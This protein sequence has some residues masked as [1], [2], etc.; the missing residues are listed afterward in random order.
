MFAPAVAGIACRASALAADAVTNA[1]ANPASPLR[2]LS[3][4]PF[5]S[6]WSSLFR[7]L[8]ALAIVLAVF[9]GGVW[10][11]RNWQ[12]VVQRRGAAPRLNIVESRSLGGRHALYVVAFEQERFLISSSPTG[13]NLLS[14]LQPAEAES[15]AAADTPVSGSFAQA[16]TQVLKGK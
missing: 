13:I 14:H 16:L 6:P 1:V 8:G 12:R 3:A 5:P 15:P 4:S 2:D 9:L 7:V 10:L 11:F